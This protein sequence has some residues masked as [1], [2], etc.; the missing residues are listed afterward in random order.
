MGH[1]RPTRRTRFAPTLVWGSALALF[2]V[3]VQGAEAQPHGEPVA[4][5]QPVEGVGRGGV[6]APSDCRADGGGAERFVYAAFQQGDGRGAAVSCA[7][8]L[9]RGTGDVA[10]RF[11]R[12]L[13]LLIPEPDRATLLARADAGGMLLGRIA[14]LDPAPATAVNERFVEHLE[15]AAYAHAQYASEGSPTGLD[16]R[17]ETYVRLG[18]PAAYKAIDFYTTELLR[19]L[20][21]LQLS[22]HN[23]FT[24]SPSEFADNEFWLYNGDE[25]FFYLFVDDGSG[26]QDGDVLDLI[27]PRFRTGVDA[28][29]GGAGPRRTFCS[30]CSAP[31]S[32][33]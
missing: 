30:K 14:L 25:P 17:G 4:F 23:G 7:E 20:R 10:E 21:D 8:A 3:G 5:R 12:V 33:S 15:R 13:A 1:T 24:V 29:T 18:A 27:P 9:A 26:Y 11:R 31:C 32:A 16:A 6:E 19:R 22:V 28:S 2:V